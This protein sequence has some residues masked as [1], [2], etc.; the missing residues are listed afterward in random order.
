MFTECSPNV[1]QMLRRNSTLIELNWDGN[2]TSAEGLLDFVG[3]LKANKILY[4]M[5]LPAR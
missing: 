1:H 5:P 4:D 3:G 2:N